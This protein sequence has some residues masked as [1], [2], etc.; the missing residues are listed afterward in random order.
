MLTQR[1][2][3]AAMQ[4]ATYQQSADGRSYSGEVSGVSG[5]CS[6]AA[7]RDACRV[8]LRDVLDTWLL[9]RQCQQSP[10]PPMDGIPLVAWSWM[11]RGM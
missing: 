9:L 1:Y 3:N 4:H 11:Q 6:Q 2:V 5:V 10:I 8:E 7:T